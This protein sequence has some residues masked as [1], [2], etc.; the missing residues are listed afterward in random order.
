MLMATN[1]ATPSADDIMKI[2]PH[3]SEH[4]MA[5]LDGKTT[6]NKLLETR[7]CGKMV[8]K[9][10]TEYTAIDHINNVNSFHRMIEEWYIHYRGVASKYINRYTALFVLVREYVGCTLQ[11]TLINTKGRLRQ[12]SDYFRVVDMNNSDLF[13]YCAF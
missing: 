7:H 8:L 6:Y 2:A 13:Y 10:H 9:D 4:C 11:E 5:W 3:N 12:F 1:T